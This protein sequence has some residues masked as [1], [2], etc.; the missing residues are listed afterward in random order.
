MTG[1]M[2]ISELADR[3]I[4]GPPHL[5]AIRDLFY[6]AGYMAE[7]LDLVR[8]FLPEFREEIMFG[9]SERRVK[10]FLDKFSQKYFPIQSG[11]ENYIELPEFVKGIPLELM[12]HS[13]DDYHNFSGYRDGFVLLMCLCGSPWLIDEDD[14]N[15]GE[16]CSHI[17]GLPSQNIRV[18]LMD[19]LENCIGKD[20]VEQVPSK[21]WN[22]NELHQMLDNTPHA[23][24]AQ[25]ADWIYHWTG[26]IILDDTYDNEEEYDWDETLVKRLTQ[27]WPQ[28]RAL[29]DAVENYC[30][31]LEKDRNSHFR[32]V[33]AFILSRTNYIVPNRQLHLESSEEDKQKNKTLMEV[34]S[35][36]GTEGENNAGLSASL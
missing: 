24:V 20:V 23:V 3:M 12:G 13:M 11:D 31:W 21:G 28:V 25:A 8:R 4:V 10:V 30:E 26:L 18:S 19:F 5:L 36:N 15:D 1:V 27:E 17:F 16:W 29:V 33:L 34:F 22:P 2:P 9:V 7:F 32:E 6:N 35:E 14:A